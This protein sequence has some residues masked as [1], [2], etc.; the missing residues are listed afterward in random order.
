MFGNE[1]LPYTNFHDLNLDW[2]I[3][4]M[5]DLAQKNED[6]DYIAE[7]AE[8]IK[9]RLEELNDLD[10]EFAEVKQDFLDLVAD[11]VTL[12]GQVQTLREDVDYELA[13]IRKPL[14]D[15]ICLT[16]SYGTNDDTANRYSWCDQLREMAGLDTAHYTK[17]YVAGGSFGDNETEKN[18]YNLFV[19]GTTGMTAERKESVSDIIIVSGIN[20][21][22]E[23][24]SLMTTNLSN[25]ATYINSNFPNAHVW[26]FAV[27]W[28]KV[29]AIRFATMGRQ[30][31]TYRDYQNAA[32][33]HGWHFVRD[34]SAMVYSNVYVDDVHPAR[35]GSRMIA[36]I[37]YNAMQGTSSPF[38]TG[39]ISP[40]TI[41]TSTATRNAGGLWFNGEAFV[42]SSSTFSCD[43]LPDL[44][45]NFLGDILLGSL[46][47]N[48]ILGGDYDNIP[49]PLNLPANLAAYN[50]EWHNISGTISLRYNPTTQKADLYFRNNGQF[51]AEAISNITDSYLYFGAAT[52]PVWD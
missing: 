40:V 42:W 26:L 27:E 31:N 34:I 52:I 20:E 17:I 16:D 15:I 9:Q 2:I 35:Q 1:N 12:S 47:T 24:R 18:R 30:N 33:D 39:F 13:T 49:S 36:S 14:T 46:N 38:N 25:L 5:K 44:P 21:W 50:G 4:T 8:E 48:A 43:A 3:K 32:R 10:E 45:G 23:S 51:P 7:Q 19:T 37:I 29:A 41:T 6:L 28:D 11:F 22:N